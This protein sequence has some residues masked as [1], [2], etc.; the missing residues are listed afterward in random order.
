MTIPTITPQQ[1]K[2]LLSEGATLVDIREANERARERVGDS[3]HLPLSKV[4]GSG[5]GLPESGVVIFHCK[6]GGRTASNAAKL[7]THAGDACNAYL[8]EGGLESW[9]KAGLPVI[10]DRSQPIELQRQVQI[11]A[12]GMGLIGTVLGATV[13][14]LFYIIPGFVGG[15]LLF[16]GITGFCG[17]AKV[18]MRAPWNR[19]ALNSSST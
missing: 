4:D 14:P 3:M 10:V 2:K 8:L 16:A 18:L 15:G 9:R 17:M 5:S 6:S 12:G 13:S 1:A 11:V 7:R 19:V